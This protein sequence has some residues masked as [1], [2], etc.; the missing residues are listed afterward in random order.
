MADVQAAIQAAGAGGADGAGDPAIKPKIDVNVEIMQMKNMIAKL[1]DAQGIP[2]PAQEMV[3]TPDKLQAMAG[4][5]AGPGGPAGG[6]DPSS[7]IAPPEPI[8]AAAPAA[9]APAM[10][11]GEK[12]GHHD[13]GRAVP[14]AANMAQ[15]SNRASAMATVLRQHAS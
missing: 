8:A 7:A 3:A 1:L 14:Q 10:A 13:R 9:A 15:L 11:G 5:E 2:M 12:V 6:S 4:G